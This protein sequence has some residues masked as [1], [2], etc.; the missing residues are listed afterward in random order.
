M[1][2]Y[3]L[4]RRSVWRRAIFVTPIVAGLAC[5]SITTRAQAARGAWLQWGGPTRNFRVDSARLAPTWPE[6]GPRQQWRRALG[7]GYSSILAAGS[8][9]VTMYRRD[10]SE[11]VVALD[12]ASGRT[13]WEYPYAAPLTHNGY[14]DV[15]LNASG[16]GPYSTPLIADDTVYAVGVTGK[17]HALDLRT[18]AVRWSNDLVASFK[19]TDYN[20]FAS[21]PIAYQGNVILPLGGSQQGV[22]AF[23][24]RTG[25]VAWRSEPRELGP[26][27]PILID[28]DGHQELVVW[29][30]QE[31]GAIDPE[32]G[33]ALW[34]HPHAAQYGLNISTPVWQPGNRLFVSSAYG[35]GSRMIHLSRR[36]G[37]TKVDELWWNTRMRLHFGSAL[38]VGDLM[39][40]ASGDFGPA[41]IVAVNADTGTEVW[42]DRSFARAQL[43]N[44]N[45]TLVIVDENGDL[46][47][48]S[49]SE[50]GLKVHAR[51]GILTSNA[52]T[53]PTLVDSILYV[54]DR[55]EVVALDL[56]R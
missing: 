48:A 41:F 43:L 52:W 35:G 2:G 20:A 14:F 49:A 7:E 23:N 27:S 39:I 45:G 4:R 33:S 42:R 34:R 12:A 46:A 51:K 54:R 5:W 24:R 47:I 55:K 50:Q 30:Q 44:A 6:G 25:T 11:I 1:A 40:G 29:G 26:G 21:S 36:D 53:P 15:W 9:L 28:V 16:P 37:Q 31:F 19:L 32:N 17:F 38:R 10:D 18:G 22:V 3:F 56:G 13:L 8:T